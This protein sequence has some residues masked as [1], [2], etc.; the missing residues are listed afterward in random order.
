MS[1]IGF[2]V[3]GSTRVHAETSIIYMNNKEYKTSTSI[4]L[5]IVNEY[6]EAK[7]YE[8]ITGKIITKEG[9]NDYTNKH[10]TLDPRTLLPY[11]GI[12]K[13]LVNLIAR[14]RILFIYSD[15]KKIQKN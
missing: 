1:K 9:K 4:L 13:E 2:A 3:Q 8:K 12:Y 14:G 5:D 10:Y 7:E 11:N 15:Y 6:S